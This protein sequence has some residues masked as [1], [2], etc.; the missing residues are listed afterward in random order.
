MPCATAV[1]PMHV[2]LSKRVCKCLT[3]MHSTSCP[4]QETCFLAHCC[5]AKRAE[6]MP[7]A[8]AVTPMHVCLSKKVCKCLTP[9][10][11]TIGQNR[12]HICASL[13]F[14]QV[15]IYPTDAQQ[16]CTGQKTCFLPLC[17]SAKAADSTLVSLQSHLCKF[18]FSYRS[19]FA[20]H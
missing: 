1:T 3:H 13:P 11:S 20:Q 5:C 19:A 12:S 18:C 9:M 8:A 17:C 4:K 10:H 14:I 6:S 16:V 2:C 7:C 15:C